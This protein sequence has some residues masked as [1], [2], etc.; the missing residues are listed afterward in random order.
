M[1]KYVVVYCYK[2]G[3]SHV[4]K[5]MYVEAEGLYEAS[6]LFFTSPDIEKVYPQMEQVC[7]RHAE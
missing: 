1:K 5:E 7:F 4:W 3:R 2:S 6:E